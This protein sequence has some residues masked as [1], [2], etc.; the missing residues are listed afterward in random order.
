MK[1]IELFEAF[2]VCLNRSNCLFVLIIVHGMIENITFLNQAQCSFTTTLRAESEKKSIK[3]SVL[4]KQHQLSNKRILCT[5]VA[6]IRM[7]NQNNGFVIWDSFVF[8]VLFEHKRHPVTC[9]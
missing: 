9:R 4:N 7:L 8:E 1:Q 6:N 3:P 2:K 5:S